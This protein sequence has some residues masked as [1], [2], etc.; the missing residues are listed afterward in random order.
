MRR[1]GG[2]GGRPGRTRGQVPDIVLTFDPS[3]G[4]SHKIQSTNLTFT[5]KTATITQRHKN[6]LLKPHNG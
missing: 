2:E 4:R 1:G 3:S 5:D 6:R